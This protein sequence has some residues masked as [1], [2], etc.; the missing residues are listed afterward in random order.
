MSIKMTKQ[1]KIDTLLYFLNKDRTD[2]KRVSFIN[3]SKSKV[4]DID[5]LIE[6]YNI[7]DIKK[8]F[9]ELLALKADREI[10]ETI[11]REQRE[12]EYKK[13]CY[14]RNS[15]F[16]EDKLASKIRY[17]KYPEYVRNYC[18]KK[19]EYEEYTSKIK[20]LK[21][22]LDKATELVKLSNNKFSSVDIKGDIVF[23]VIRGIN[24]VCDYVDKSYSEIIYE[25][26][27]II[28]VIKDWRNSTIMI[29]KRIK[30]SKKFKIVDWR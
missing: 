2:N 24:L 3:L 4:S 8:T 16:N 28:D 7:P 17:N 5:K 21:I 30:G 6:K 1:D 9:G 12:N 11:E 25:N 26:D 10:K 14:E 19:V 13:I 22:N 23:A 20:S 15:M 27:C 29:G 18:E